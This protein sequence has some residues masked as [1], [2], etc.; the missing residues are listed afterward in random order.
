VLV[1]PARGVD[2]LA[3]VPLPAQQRDD[4]DR[5]VDKLDRVPGEN[6]GPPL[7]VGCRCEPVSI[8]K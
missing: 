2:L 7:K 5:Q 8:V 4:D 3:E 1:L 6:A